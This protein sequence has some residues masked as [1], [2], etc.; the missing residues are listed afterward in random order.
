MRINLVQNAFKHLQNS[1][2]IV[3]ESSRTHFG[4]TL[5]FIESLM[6]L[7]FFSEIFTKRNHSN[8]PV[9]ELILRMNKDSTIIQGYL[10]QTMFFLTLSYSFGTFN[11]AKNHKNMGVHETLGGSKYIKTPSKLIQNRVGVIT[12]TFWINFETHKTDEFCHFII[13]SLKGNVRIAIDKF[14]SSYF[15]WTKIQTISE[16]TLE[17][18][19]KWKHL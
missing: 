9:Q 16:M 11:M 6:S 3:L 18:N 1:S 10:W 7:T 2:K 17:R 4:S 8:L 15:A 5:K 19:Q 12:N 13:L 14:R